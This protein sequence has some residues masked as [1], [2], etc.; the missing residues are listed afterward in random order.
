LSA[1]PLSLAGTP[2]ASPL[3][4]YS[5][6]FGQAARDPYYILVVIYIFF[7]YFSNAVVGDPMRGQSLIGYLNATA[8][9]LLAVTA[10]FLG[11]I[12]DKNG[13]RKPWVA[14]TVAGDVAGRHAAVVRAAGRRVAWASRAAFCCCW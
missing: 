6:T 1:Q 9:A 11:A 3:G 2:A 4:Y 10:P 12:A 7:P 8:G 14:G 5:W 13:R